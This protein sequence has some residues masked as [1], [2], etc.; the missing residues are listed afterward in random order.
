MPSVHAF[1]SPA[2]YRGDQDA[3]DLS[4]LTGLPV[5]TI[6]NLGCEGGSLIYDG[7]C[8]IFSA[9]SLS[10][11]S[12]QFSFAPYSYVDLGCSA[13][14]HQLAVFDAELKAVALGLRDWMVKTHSKGYTLSLSGGADSAL[15]ATCVALSQL[16]SLL[17]LGVVAYGQMLTDLGA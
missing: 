15:C 2:S 17:D 4:R 16:Y 8:Q 6:N 14:P 1:E 10:A 7:R 11:T 12:T 5:I 13:D 3:A 9:G